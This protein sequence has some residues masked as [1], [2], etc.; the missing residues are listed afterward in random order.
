LKAEL[1][2]LS[3]G[4]RAELAEFL[5][6]SLDNDANG[7][8]EAEAAFAAELKRR[9]DEIRSGKVVGIPAEQMFRELREKYS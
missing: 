5:M 7:V 8:P 3:V 4:E 2:R 6:D 9:A 1:T